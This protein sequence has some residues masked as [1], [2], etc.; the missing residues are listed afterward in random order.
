MGTLSCTINDVAY[1]VKHDLGGGNAIQSTKTL[2]VRGILTITIVDTAGAFIFQRGDRIAVSDSITGDFYTGFIQ[3]DQ[4]TPYGPASTAIDHLLTCFDKWYY[5]DKGAN[6]VNH[7]NEYAGDIVVRMVN[8][9]Q[10]G[11][12]GATV[13]AGLHRDATVAQW[14]QG[15]LSGVV[16]AS[17]VGDGDL[18]LS[19]A[20]SNVSYSESTTSDFAS[21]TLTNCVASNNT[22]IPTSTNAIKMVA[23]M[24]LAGSTATN[25]QTSVLVWSGSQA[26]SSVTNWLEYDCFIDPAA[27]EAKM[28]VDV[29]FSDGTTFSVL[30]NT[31]NGNEDGQFI[32]P[33]ASNDLKGLA[34]TAWYHRML[35]LNGFGGKTIAGI[36]LTCKGTSAGTY[37]GY[38]KNIQLTGTN[39]ATFFSS[40]LNVNPPQQLQ[41][42]GYSSTALS[43]VSTYDLYSPTAPIYGA[44][45]DKQTNSISIDAVKLYRTSFISWAA[46]V[47]T[48][49]ALVVKYS[50]DGGTSYIPC[51]NGAALPD[52]PAGLVTTGKSII[53]D[54]QFYYLAGALPDSIITLEEVALTLYTSYAATKSDVTYSATSQANWN[55]GTLTNLTANSSNELTLNG[56]I[57]TWDDG[58]NANQT[59]YDVSPGT[60]QQSV[61]NRSFTIWSL[62]AN[63]TVATE[64]KSR[65]DFAANTWQNFTAE[66]DI[67]ISDDNVQYGLVYRTTGWQNNNNT[68]AYVAFVS[69]TGGV[70]L[71]KG[72]N[73]SSGSGS[74]TT[75]HNT[76]ATYAKGSWHRLKVVVSG[77]SHK[78]YIDGI[79]MISVTDSTYSA[80]GYLGIRIFENN[81]TGGPFTAFFDNFGVASTLSGTWV[82]PGTSLASA[83]NYGDSIITWRDKSP[84]Y[85]GLTNTSILVEASYDNGSTYHTCTNGAAL[86]ALTLGQSLTSATLKIRVT[87]T[88]SSAASLA[89][90]D[91]LIVR[92]LG[93]YSASGTRTTAPMGIDYVDR[94]NQSGFGTASDGQSYVKV[95]TA[96]DAVASNKLTI[97]N[98]TGDLHEKFGSRTGNNLD[99]TMRFS[100]SAS[101]MTSGSELRYVDTNNYYRL[102]ASTTALSII[103]KSNGVTTTLKTVSV[104]LSTGTLYYLRFRVVNFGPTSLYGRVW[105]A[106]TLEPTNWTATITD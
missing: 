16:G 29:L 33:D 58:S 62:I 80:A 46:I 78:V 86:P 20:G 85:N 35:S 9:G 55:A 105:A 84:S 99:G 25:A 2:G 92:V 39:T 17:N 68:F 49:C 53:L 67:E 70:E 7:A 93:Q 41:V 23:V 83:V 74:Y 40:S 94:A 101:T 11:L 18:E 63:A 89:A 73:S 77:S 81:T 106:G 31:N 64:A 66:M 32:L 90:I 59:F 36:I 30:A 71:G 72:S 98:T 12:E 52:F 88:T 61:N 60:P 79:Q 48:N 104:T 56:V 47:P 50:L 34:T 28:A 103:K 42:Y 15:Q 91:N 45:A 69:T 57:R 1:P 27:P 44:N 10:P 96:T 75:I 21:G 65:F 5:L 43:V 97:T 13:A 76:S 22:L 38:F 82:S 100:L 54:Y 102:A 87:L 6:T 24:A 3:S 37:T 14:S 51:T 95:G 8:E 4:Q 26:V 19:P